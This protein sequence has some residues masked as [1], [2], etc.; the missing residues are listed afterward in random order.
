MSTSL[1]PT[2]LRRLW[3]RLRGGRTTPARLGWSVATG[4]FIGCQPLYGLHFP[5]CAGVGLPLRLDVPL[6]Y[7]AANVSNPLLA[8][9]ILFAELQCGARL[10]EGAWLPLSVSEVRLQGVGRLVAEAALGALVVGGLLALLGGLSAWW[11]ARRWRSR[12][13]ANW[14][15]SATRETE[16]N[17]PGL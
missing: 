1:S 14:A 7:L 12:R 6:A 15:S 11:L 2:T 5:L 17:A 13:S 9:F 4:L 10:L 3:R 16:L 8:P